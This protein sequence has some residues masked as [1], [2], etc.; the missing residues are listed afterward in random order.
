MGDGDFG[1]REAMRA[2]ARLRYFFTVSGDASTSYYAMVSE[3]KNKA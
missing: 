3:L 1:L 2:L